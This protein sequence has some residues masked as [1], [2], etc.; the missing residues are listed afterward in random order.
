MRPAEPLSRL[1]NLGF[2][3][4]TAPGLTFEQVRLARDAFQVIGTRPS[5]GTLVSVAAISASAACCEAAIAAAFAELD[6]LVPIFSRH[7]PD[8]A[9]STLNDAGRLA[10]PPP[11]LVRVLERSLYFHGLSRG[12]FDVTVKPV[13]DLLDARFPARAPSAAEL[14]DVAALIG[15]GHL[16]VGRR[17]I[18]FSRPG[19]GVTLDG[20]AKGDIVDRMADVLTCH[21]VR[22]FLINAGGD[23][24]AAGHK[25]GHR[26]WTVG[27]R[28]PSSGG[29]LP[30]AIELRD[31]AVA[32][33]GGYERFYDSE[34]LFHHIIN[35]ASGHS[36][37]VAW[38]VSVW[39]PT[40][41]AAD[42]LAT[43]V[44]VL[45]PEAGMRLLETLSD[46]AG[47]I[48]TEDGVQRPSRRWRW[49]SR[50]Q[51]EGIA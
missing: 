21:G 6:R 12:A 41:L 30:G 3:V 27:V 4:A 43:T 36:A 50:N 2:Q 28:D 34:R 24:R 39:A 13:L 5:L 18:R 20:I 9:L 8:S 14:R 1:R 23:V 51:E 48:V 11:E 16:S 49:L 35:P 26:P 32:T 31:G 22:R 45:G 38:S 15:A 33:S 40:S 25:E 47:L 42:A 44:F 7:E 19:M 46:C 37:N 29:V 10:G 17:A